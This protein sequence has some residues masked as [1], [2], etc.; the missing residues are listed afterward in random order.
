MPMPLDLGASVDQIKV[1]ELFLNCLIGKHRVSK[2]ILLV[3]AVWVS[4]AP[5]NMNIWFPV[6]AEFGRG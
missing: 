4:N 1:Y 3:V 2:G 5:H 6:M